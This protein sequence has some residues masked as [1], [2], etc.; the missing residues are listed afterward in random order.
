MEHY[1]PDLPL[2]AVHYVFKR[3][4]NV[5]CNVQKLKTQE[6]KLKI[7]ELVKFNNDNA[8]KEYE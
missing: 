2:L 4:F 7:Q 6:M 8:K 1:T 3:F 5:K